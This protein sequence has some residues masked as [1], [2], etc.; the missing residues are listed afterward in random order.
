MIKKIYLKNFRKFNELELDTNN[1]IIVYTGPNAVG[2]TSVLESIYL[3]STSKSHR[4]LDLETMI[5]QNEEYSIIEIE[6]KI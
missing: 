4:T 5:L 3:T 6:E 1:N 2:K